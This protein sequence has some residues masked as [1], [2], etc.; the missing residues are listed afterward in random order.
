LNVGIAR[1]KL[2]RTLLRQKRHSEAEGHL[3]AAHAIFTKHGSQAWLRNVQED[4]AAVY[5]ALNQ[6][7]K[8]ERFRLELSQNQSAK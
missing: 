5:T 1:S 4:L 2:G 8:A 7:V 6:P 3:A